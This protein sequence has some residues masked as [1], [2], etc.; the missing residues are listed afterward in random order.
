MKENLLSKENP[1]RDDY[2][3]ALRCADSGDYG[4]LIKLQAN[5]L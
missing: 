1:H 2:V 4:A 3:K 5:T